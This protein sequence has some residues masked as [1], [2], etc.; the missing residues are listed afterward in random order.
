MKEIEQ[1]AA[2]RFASFGV[3]KRQELVRLLFEISRRE[4]VAVSAI[5]ANHPAEGGNTRFSNVKRRLLQRR[6]PEWQGRSKGE[7]PVLK[8]VLTQVPARCDDAGTFAPR[9]VMFEKSVRHSERLKKIVKAFPETAVQEICSFSQFVKNADYDVRDYN[10]RRET[11]FIVQEKH[12]FLQGCPCSS[13]ARTCGYAVFQCGQ[14]CPLEC[15]YCFLQAYVNAPGIVL[16]ASLEDHFRHLE[17]HAGPL[18]MGS[19]QFLDSLALDHLSGFSHDIIRFL[20][21]RPDCVFEFKTK[22]D[23]VETLLQESV[24][25]NVIVGW[26]LNPQEYIERYE[27]GAASLERRLKAA[28]QCVHQGVRV[29]FHFD[30]I[31]LQ[32]GWPQKY[33]AVIKMIFQRIDA[34]MI[35]WISLGTLRFTARLKQVMEQ[36]FPDSDLWSASMVTGYDGKLRYPRP[37]RVNAYQQLLSRIRA[38]DQRV[39]VYL[40]MEHLDVWQAVGLNADEVMKSMQGHG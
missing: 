37:Q 19:G 12:A 7:L 23:Q 35:S 1:Y 8:K 9:R 4:K 18:R 20:H 36:R 38:C 5:L 21:R 16:P 25:D 39:P 27:A 11:L 29:S 31:I 6:Y 33:S 15:Q 30:P 17:G 2:Q 14:G 10:L 32:A 28:Q 22:T 40:C 24:P 13:G 34:R 3:N 26:S